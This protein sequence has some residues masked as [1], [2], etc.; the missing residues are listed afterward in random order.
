[1]VAV[2]SLPYRLPVPVEAVLQ[3]FL[4]GNPDYAGSA[5]LADTRAL[6]A[7][8]QNLKPWTCRLEGNQITATHGIAASIV[9]NADG[10]WPESAPSPYLDPANTTRAVCPRTGRWDMVGC[11]SW[12]NNV[13]G[14][15][16][17]HIVK[18]GA[19]II[20]SDTRPATPGTFPTDQQVYASDILNAG[21]YVELR[22]A[23]FSGGNLN[24]SVVAGCPSLTM[25]RLDSVL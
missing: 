1:M 5:L 21:D 15:R 10:W 23:Q 7:I 25:R 3:A 19:T 20:G 13:V 16:V 22:G 9:W 24:A 12:D 11:L 6:E 14:Q 18:N 4:S 2:P 8:L 17:A